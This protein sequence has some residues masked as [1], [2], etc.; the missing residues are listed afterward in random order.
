MFRTA[1]L[2]SL[3]LHGL[4]KERKDTLILCIMAEHVRSYCFV[5][6]YIFCIQERIC[7]RNEHME[8]I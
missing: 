5:I 1:L 7:Y 2:I 8:K 6:D 4:K 3:I